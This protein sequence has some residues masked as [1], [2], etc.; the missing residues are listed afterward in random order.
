MSIVKKI[1]LALVIFIA[2]LLIVALFVKKEYV[3]EREITIKKPNTTVYDY[4]RYLK[5]QDNYSVWASLDPDMKREYKGI[6]GTVGFI[7]A[8]D[9]ENQDA[10]KGEQEIINIEE[11]QRVDY[12]I[13]FKEPFES[14]GNTY[15]ITQQ[16]D[17]SSTKVTWGYSGEMAY[18]TNLLL[19]LI[20][21]DNM[22]G[23][24]LE[25]GLL[26]LKDILE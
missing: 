11:G 23:P 25:Q 7:A 18:P 6:D 9:S 2:L 4:I 19:L 14:K 1:L 21:M 24:D 20:N 13:R 8:W 3:I 10:G 16:I 26:N 5:N 12:E 15:L 17:A 22:L